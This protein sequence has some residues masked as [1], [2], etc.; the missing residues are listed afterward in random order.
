MNINETA[1]RG[2]ARDPGVYERGRPGFAPEAI[3]RLATE[4][5][6]EPGRV[7]VDLAAGT[8]KLTREIVRFGAQLVAVEPLPE[9]RRMFSAAV[10]GVDVLAGTAEAIPLDDRSV[11]TVLVAQAFHWFDAPLAAREIHRILVPG[12][13]LGIVANVFDESVTWVARVQEQVRAHIGDAPRH[14]TSP[15][16]DELARTRLFSPLHALEAS[17]VV[18]GDLDVLAA[19]V[20][21]IS[22]ISTLEDDK[23][24]DLQTRVRAIGAEAL[25]GGATLEMPYVTRIWWCQSR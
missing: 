1:A 17:H 10:P 5:H 8:G 25:V 12:G 14:D 16:R 9:M 2:F 3:E 21:S 4:L 24:E 15:W 11:D 13:G 6:I 20:A 23:R 22:Y 7:V 18:R 19:R